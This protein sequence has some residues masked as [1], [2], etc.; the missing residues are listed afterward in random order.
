MTV[1]LDAAPCSLVD[2]DVSE[3][4]TAFVI[5]LIIKAVSSSETSVIIYQ[6]VAVLGGI[7]VS[8]LSIELKVR[9]LKHGRERW[10]FKD[11][12]NP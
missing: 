6:T 7:I 4:L 3:V 8:V 9:G 5:T 10:T 2:T 12:K 1:F 11:D